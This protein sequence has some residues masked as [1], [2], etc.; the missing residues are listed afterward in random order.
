MICGFDSIWRE[1]VVVVHFALYILSSVCVGYVLHK[2]WAYTGPLFRLGLGSINLGVLIRVVDFLGSGCRTVTADEF[3][4][5]LGFT[6][7]AV[8]VVWLNA[9]GSKC[10]PCLYDISKRAL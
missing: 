4:F 2:T 10:T 3:F 1:A 9:T 6:L 7:A 8:W 5:T